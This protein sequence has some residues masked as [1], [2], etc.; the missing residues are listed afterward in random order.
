[1]TT[2][3]RFVIQDARP[4]SFHLISRCVRRAFLCGD[5]AEHRRAWLEQG[6]KTQVQ[7][8]AIDVLTFAVMSNHLHIVVKTD[9]HRTQGWT[10]R[11]VAERWGLLFP[12]IDAD[13]GAAGQWTAAD[14]D[15]CAANPAWIETR[16]ARLASVS[17]FMR[18]LKQR[19]ARRANAEDKVTGHFWEGRF[20]SVALLDAAAVVSCMAYVDLNPIRA[21]IVTTPEASDYTGIQLR[22]EARQAHRKTQAVLVQAP[23]QVDLL[24][25]ETARLRAD[26]GPE[27]GLWIAP[28]L[29]ATAGQLD[30]D[31]YLELVDQTGRLLRGD[32][33][34]HI[35]A[36]LAPILERL[37]IDVA[38][39]LD[40]MRSRGRFLGSAVGAVIHLVSEAT[41]RGLKWVIDTTGIHRDRRQRAIPV[42][43]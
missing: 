30:V 41:R 4:G 14:I 18:L 21:A 42:T 39:W 31:T 43:A 13:T 7:A 35:P 1:M 24:V 5:A 33:R 38:T 16:R 3:R 34:G 29:K 27:H 28:C 37:H 19:I 25:A 9:P 36:H 40:V 23:Q 22:I 6:I 32:K 17:W 10:G 20:H 8:F 2:P 11:E 15:R 26:Q 12:K